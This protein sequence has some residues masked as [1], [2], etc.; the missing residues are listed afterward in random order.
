MK[1]IS[2]KTIL[3]AILT[4]SVTAAIAATLWAVNDVK[5]TSDRLGVD[6]KPLMELI[7]E[8]QKDIKNCEK[9][10]MEYLPSFKACYGDV[11]IPG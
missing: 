5:E 4:A 8:E 7:S 6:P 3:S 10:G 9:Y 1:K 2:L 11:K